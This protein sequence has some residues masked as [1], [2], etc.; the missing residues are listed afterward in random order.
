MRPHQQADTTA[1]AAPDVTVGEAVA[2]AHGV[3]FGAPGKC[4]VCGEPGFL[5]YVDMKRGISDS[6]CRSCR[7]TWNFTRG[8]DGSAILVDA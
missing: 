3:R 8:A 2:V 1:P 7:V 6:S 4:P 5:D